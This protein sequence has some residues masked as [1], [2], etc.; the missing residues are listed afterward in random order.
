MATAPTFKAFT[1]TAV[2][3]VTAPPTTAAHFALWN[4]AA[5]GGPS[6]YLQTVEAF[7]AASAGAAQ[8]IQLFAHL[9]ANA[10][11]R[12]GSGFTAASGPFSLS[13]PV[14]PSV[15]TVGSAVTIV[16]DSVWHACSLSETMG[17]GTTTIANGTFSNV[18]GLYVV[19]PGMVF[20]LAVLCSAAGT[21]TCKCGV[22]WYEQ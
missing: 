11:S 18:N 19:A 13:G 4:S 7:T 8:I 21:A 3:P 6:L 12:I 9:G 14:A 17:A 20:S 15:A 16:N 5:P 10:Q 2:T 22:T 1:A